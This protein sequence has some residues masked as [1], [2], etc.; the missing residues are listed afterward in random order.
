MDDRA[1]I[2]RNMQQLVRAG[3]AALLAHG[4]TEDQVA[5]QAPALAAEALSFL[6]RKAAH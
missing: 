6:Q 4:L 5:A 1:A 3:A 2:I